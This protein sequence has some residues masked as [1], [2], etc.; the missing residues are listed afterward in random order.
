MLI[1]YSLFFV[2]LSILLINYAIEIYENS[3]LF[4]RMSD[5]F[6]NLENEPR[7]ETYSLYF[8][9]MKDMWFSGFG[10]GQSSYGIYGALND[11]PHNFILEFGS[12]FGILGFIFI[13][14]LVIYTFFKKKYYFDN[15]KSYYT[16]SM[17][18]FM[19]MFFIFSKSFGIY[20]SYLLFLAF[21]FIWS[22]NKSSIQNKRKGS[23]IGE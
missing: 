20:D 9:A 7:F 12:E 19:Y 21:G 3:V 22:F 18:F 11:Y 15:E 16:M 6:Y 17:I 23:L 1:F 2:I 8:S 14:V 10:I 5:L 13:S 4:I